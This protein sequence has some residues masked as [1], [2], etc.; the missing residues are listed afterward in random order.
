L[1]VFKH[2]QSTTIT[3]AVLSCWHQWIADRILSAY[4][5]ERLALI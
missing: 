1:M 2:G 3:S 5:K 4:Y